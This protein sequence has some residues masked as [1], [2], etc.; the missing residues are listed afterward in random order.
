VSA[1][2]TWQFRPATKNGVRVKV[3]I[4]LTTTFKL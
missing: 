4:T 1:I 2:K 3:H